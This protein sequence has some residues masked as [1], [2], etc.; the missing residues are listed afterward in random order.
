MAA[1]SVPGRLRLPSAPGWTSG[2]GGL[3]F[4]APG[5]FVFLWSTGFIGAKYGL[6]NAAPLSFLLVR[7]L[8][9]I[10]LMLVLAWATKAPWPKGGRLWLRIGISGLLVHAAYLG[11]VYLSIANGLPVGVSSIIVGLQPLLTAVGAAALLSERIVPRQWLGL[12]LGLCGTLLVVSARVNGGFGLVGL[13]AAFGALFGITA[14]TLYQKRFCPNFDYRTGA[15]IQFV[16]AAVV[17]GLAMSF[18]EDYRVE[19]TTQF[20]LALSWLSIVLSFGAVGL[21]NFLIRTGTATNVASLFYLVPPCTAVIAWL[22]FDEA[23]SGLVMLGMALAVSGV[24]LS[25]SEALNKVRK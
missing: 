11:G 5:L 1:D 19:W 9:V 16:P 14:G 25:R 6:P 24:Y 12:V 3:A 22:A 18:Y 4:W 13:P 23:L 8:L 15:I 10:G 2:K 21:L 7:Y 20:I 17:T